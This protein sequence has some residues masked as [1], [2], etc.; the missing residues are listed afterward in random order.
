MCGCDCG[1]LCW[2]L[3]SIQSI[4]G[5]FVY[6]FGYYMLHNNQTGAYYEIVDAGIGKNQHTGD[7]EHLELRVVRTEIT[8]G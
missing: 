6:A 1:F 7:I 4:Y 2:T 8:N 5:A 3:F